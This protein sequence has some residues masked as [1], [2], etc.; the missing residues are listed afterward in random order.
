MALLALWDINSKFQKSVFLKLDKLLVNSGAAHAGKWV[1]RPRESCLQ[2]PNPAI[3][4]PMQG[5]S[6]LGA[7]G[8]LVDWD[9]TADLGMIIV[10]TIVIG[11]QYDTM[12][13][14]HM[15]WMASAVQNG[16]YLYCPNGS[17]MAQYDDQKT[18]FEGLVQF[19]QDVDSG[20]F[21]LA[22]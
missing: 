2:A 14:K 16:R 5:P 10:P 3:Y 18:Y 11:A 22:A 20:R 12:D 13:P 9:R 6:E 7:S 15:E 19:V 8:K 17:H 21:W 4:V 1:A